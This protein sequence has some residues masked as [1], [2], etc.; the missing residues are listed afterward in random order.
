MAN[1]LIDLDGTVCDDIANE[2]SH[3]YADAKP[4]TGA[5]DKL[6]ELQ[7]EH[8]LTYFTARE[9]KDR[10]VTIEWLKK[11]GFPEARLIMDKPRGGNYIWIDNHKGRYVRFRNSLYKWNDT[12]VTFLKNII[13]K[14]VNYG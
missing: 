12:F 6:R 1:L 8:A 13:E 3:K 10:K 4:Y 9:E 7:G 5:A 14:T 2:E 11:H